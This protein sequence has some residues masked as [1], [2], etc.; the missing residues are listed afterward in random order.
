MDGKIFVLL[1]PSLTLQDPRLRQDAIYILELVLEHGVISICTSEKQ[2]IN[3]N[4]LACQI[5]ISPPCAIPF[6]SCPIHLQN[7]E[8]TPEVTGLQRGTDL[9]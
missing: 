7:S 2:Q 6:S 9:H 5:A 4:S 3:N 1:L 8:C